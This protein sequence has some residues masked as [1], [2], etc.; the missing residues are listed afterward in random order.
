M[1]GLSLTTGL[2]VGVMMI[3]V[4]GGMAGFVV[5]FRSRSWGPHDSEKHNPEGKP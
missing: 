1:S 5:L 2:I 3:F 4:V